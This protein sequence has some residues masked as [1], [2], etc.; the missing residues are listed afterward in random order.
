MMNLIKPCKLKPGDKIATVSLSWGGA[1]N[2]EIMWRYLQGK[3]R[4]KQVFGLEVVEMENTLKGQEYLYNN[5]EKRAEDLMNAFKDPSIKGI[6]CCTGGSDTIRTLPYI[7]FDVIKNNPKVFMGYSDSTVN[8]FMCLKAGVSS[9]YGPS[10]L[11]DFGENI[12]IPEYTINSVRNVLFSNSAVGNINCSNFWSG[13]KLLWLERN[14]HIQRNF[15]KNTGYELLQGKGIVRGELIGGC[16]DVIRY[17]K[18]TSIFPSL[19][20]FDKAILFLETSEVYPK[21][22]L[23]QDDLRWFG[24]VGILGKISGILWGRPQ[25]GRYY[26]EYK[27]I[28]KKVLKEYCAEDIPVLYNASFG[29]NEPKT[30]LPYGA[31]AEIDCENTSFSIID[32]AVI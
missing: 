22:W 10:V 17:T 5:P 15:I 2:T 14:K 20:S 29:H 4:L 25:K 27:K 19:E 8:H 11:S 13:D 7:N 3:K 32:S 12:E 31:M 16:L 24:A 18:G 26:E 23:L 30:V 1:G 9:F 28:I 21:P 6:I